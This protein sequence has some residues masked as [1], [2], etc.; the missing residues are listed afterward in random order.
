MKSFD[1]LKKAPIRAGWRVSQLAGRHGQA[2]GPKTLAE[3]KKQRGRHHP[4]IFE[5]FEHR[6]SVR[7]PVPFG[8][9]FLAFFRS[10][11]ENRPKKSN[12]LA[13]IRSP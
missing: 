11:R 9:E 3:I 12:K 10:P 7:L 6:Q 2:T 5:R 8:E 13:M 4:A 1:C